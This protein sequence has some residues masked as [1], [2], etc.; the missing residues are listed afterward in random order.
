MGARRFRYAT[1]TV[2]DRKGDVSARFEGQ[3]VR[4]DR[5]LVEAAAFRGDAQRSTVRHGITSVDSEVQHDLF[6]LAPIG[7]NAAE[8]GI[9]AVVTSMS[10]PIRR[11]S[12]P[13]IPLTTEFTSR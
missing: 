2:N 10:S 12:S 13:S 6:Q 5:V 9:E 8:L 3:A 7:E 11:L 1:T 4:C